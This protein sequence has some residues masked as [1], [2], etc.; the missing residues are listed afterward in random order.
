MSILDIIK[1]LNISQ[2]DRQ[3]MEYLF[4]LNFIKITDVSFIYLLVFCIFV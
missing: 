4:N 1:L 2:I 3:E